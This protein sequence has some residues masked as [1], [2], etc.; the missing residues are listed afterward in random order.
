MG[1]G[2]E[3]V[4]VSAEGYSGADVG[5]LVAGSESVGGGVDGDPSVEVV[6]AGLVGSE[7]E[8]LA[9]ALV[10]VEVEAG[11]SAAEVGSAD[12]GSVDCVADAE[13]GSRGGDGWHG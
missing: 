4:T 11:A 13:V 3:V 10:V 8:A 1:M 7:I 5:A 2:A 12:V 6:E 9:Y